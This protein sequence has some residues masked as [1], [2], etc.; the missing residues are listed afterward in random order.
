MITKELIRLI[1]HDIQEAL[2]SVAE[3][4]GVKIS[5]GSTSYSSAD[6]TTKV[7]VETAQAEQVK[8]EESKRYASMLG[9][10]DDIIGKT[11]TLKGQHYEVIRLDIGKPKN[12]VI[13]KKAGS[14]G[15][16]KVSVDTAKRNIKQ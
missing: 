1:N 3:K 6:F 9:L 13:I 7:K 11:I 10:P 15:T 12:P 14:E 5:L 2:K 4:H 8:G 16:Y